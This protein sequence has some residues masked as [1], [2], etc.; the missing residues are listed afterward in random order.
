MPIAISAINIYPVKSLGGISVASA[1]LGYAGLDHDRAWMVVKP[2]G[3]FIT[4]RTHP[5]M[6]LVNAD[7]EQDQLIL[8]SFGMESHR[9]PVADTTMNRLH[10]EVWGDKVYAL[11]TGDASAQWLSQA[12]DEECRLVAFPSNEIRACDPQRSK[13]SDHTR[14]ADGFPLLILSEASL[15][16]LNNRLEMPVGM[17]R[18]RPNIVVKGC[19]AFAE[20]GW[21]TIE[22]NGLPVRIVDTCPRCSVPTVDPATGALTGPEPIHTLSTYRERDGEVFFGVNAAPDQEGLVS[23][24]DSVN[25]I[26]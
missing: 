9:V 8:N 12:L 2:D 21:S 17:E 7:I 16:D 22:I 3:Q 18:F 1:N 13:S 23:I 5:Q 24:G 25:L 26:D 11:D 10:S 19:L 14:F 6:A 20:D 15:T 4:Q